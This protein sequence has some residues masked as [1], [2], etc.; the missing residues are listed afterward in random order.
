MESKIIKL[1]EQL[2]KQSGYTEH[3]TGH[4]KLLGSIPEIDSLFVASLLAHLESEFQIHIDDDELDGTIFESVES[5][6]VFI[7][8]KL[9]TIQE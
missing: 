7:Q 6:L 5:L 8:S 9:K 1:L 2:L 4:S 3:L